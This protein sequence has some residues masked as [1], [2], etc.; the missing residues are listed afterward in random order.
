MMKSYSKYKFSPSFYMRDSYIYKITLKYKTCDN[1]V[2]KDT[3]Y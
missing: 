3:M 2:L 1:F